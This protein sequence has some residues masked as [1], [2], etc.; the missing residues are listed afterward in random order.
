MGGIISETRQ[1]RRRRERETG[2]AD[3]AA[4]RARSLAQTATRQPKTKNEFIF[5]AYVNTFFG[6]FLVA[7]GPLLTRL[8]LAELLSQPIE[9]QPEVYLMC[10]VLWG[11]LFYELQG[12]PR[13]RL[14]KVAE[15]NAHVLFHWSSLVL[16]GSMAVAYAFVGAKPINGLGSFLW[17]PWLCAGWLV[18][19]L[20]GYVTGTHPIK[21]ANAEEEEEQWQAQ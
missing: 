11:S 15:R 21:A 4:D 18:A 13:D 12:Y 7:A 3:E 6:V 16:A 9:V 17:N 5:V 2:E 8:A 14:K 19:T 1:Q 20:A 10:L